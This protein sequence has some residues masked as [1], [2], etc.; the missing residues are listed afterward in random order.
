M[1]QH[2]ALAAAIVAL[3]PLVPAQAPAAPE[4]PLAAQGYLGLTAVDIASGDTVVSWILPGPLNG[5]GLEAPAADLARPDLLVAIDGRALHAAELCE[6]VHGFAPGTRVRLEWRRAKARGGGIPDRLDHEDEVQAL[7]VVL[8]AREEW[9]GM[10]GRSRVLA[11][12]AEI[13]FPCM[14][15]PLDPE[16]D[17]GAEIVTH[18]PVDPPRTLTGVLADYLAKNDDFHSL[19]RL[20]A[21][22]E[23]PFCLPELEHSLVAPTLLVPAHP[24]ESAQRL[25]LECLEGGPGPVFRTGEDEL[26]PFD[27]I[28]MAAADAAN[29][30]AAEQRDFAAQ[31]LSFLR[32]PRRTFYLRGPETRE[33]LAVVRRSMEVSWDRLAEDLCDLARVARMTKENLAALAPILR[34]EPLEGEAGAPGAV[35]GEIA[36]WVRLIDGLLVVVG[37][38][39]PNRYDLAQIAIVIDPGGNDEYHATGL[40][41]GRRAILEFARGRSLL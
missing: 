35:D 3:A 34:S 9:T 28:Q 7:E 37:G 14:L 31:C 6:Y 10:I 26:G 2:R 21:P 25:V 11:G 32:V 29:L 40:R 30:P 1:T 4:K 19:R 13:P 16:N 39:G 38:D 22:F 36:G 20:R 41:L 12:R 5:E 24:L 8:A 17:L 23:D 15:A 18:G 27:W 33:H